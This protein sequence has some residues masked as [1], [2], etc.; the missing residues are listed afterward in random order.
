MLPPRRKSKKVMNSRPEA[1][2]LRSPGHLAFVRK[3]EC[4]AAG[5]VDDSYCA[6]LIEAAHVRNG[7]KCGIGQKPG[8]DWVISLCAFHHMRQH[9]MGEARF[10]ATYNIDMKALA[11]EFA[12]ASPAL[13]KLKAK[14]Q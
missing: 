13:R 9:A 14:K 12:A 10:E 7:V 4:S 11:R 5:K 1:G 3:H 8:D 2:P 6:G